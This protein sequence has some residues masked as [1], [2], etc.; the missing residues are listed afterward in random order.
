MTYNE[1]IVLSEEE[2]KNLNSST[3]EETFEAWRA[4]YLYLARKVRE[5]MENDFQDEFMQKMS[6]ISDE[7]DL[8]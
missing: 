8:E 5:S 1:L 3:E 4:G 7:A 6:E 2:V